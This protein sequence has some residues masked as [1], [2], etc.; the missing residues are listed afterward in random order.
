MPW[1]KGERVND[2]IEIND[3]VRF[4]EDVQLFDRN[5][6]GD[7]WYV[8]NNGSDTYTAGAAA[9]NGRAPDAAFATLGYAVSQSAAWDTIIY[10]PATDCSA[11]LDSDNMPI[12]L[13]DM[14]LRIIGGLTSERQWGSPA[15]HSHGTDS[16]IYINNHQIEIANMGF[17]MQGAAPACIE[18]GQDTN[19][20][21]THIHGCY[22]GGN[23]TALVGIV[24]GNVTGSGYGYGSTVDAPCTTIENC[25]FDQFATAGIYMNCGYGSVVRNCGFDI[26]TANYGIIYGNSTTSRPFGYILDN[27]FTTTDST[28]AVGIEVVNTPSAGY[29][30]VRGNQFVN[31][32][33]DD[34]CCSKRTGY[35][36]LNYAGVTAVTITT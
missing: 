32:A 21:R 25:Y 10:L 3:K 4:Q 36:G 1:L 22:F 6:L 12:E 30:F 11:Y 8:R 15:L 18:V 7:T 23:N 13:D 16:M 26:G 5:L 31:F 35:M 14:G 17:H 34:H 2:F 27:D 29:F 24:A 9:K 20:W 19:T 33:D 28:N